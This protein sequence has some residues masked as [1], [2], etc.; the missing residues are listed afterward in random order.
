[1]SKSYIL[2]LFSLFSFSLLQAQK[3]IIRGVIK[4]KSDRQTIIGASV[5][6]KGS[7]SVNVANTITDVQGQFIFSNL[8]PGPYSIHISFIGY[9]TL[10]ESLSLKPNEESMLEFKLQQSSLNLKTVTVE[11]MQSRMEQKGD[12]TQFNADAFKTNPDANAEDLISKMPGITNEGGS[13][14][15]GGEDVR[16]RKSVV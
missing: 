1:L 10:N 2:L 13:V 4:D 6:L 3:G 8:S 12:T 9:E 7:D 16:D 11:G 15:A 14:K 5:Q